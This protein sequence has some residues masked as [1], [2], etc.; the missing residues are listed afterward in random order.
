[1]NKV[2]KSRAS[3]KFLANHPIQHKLF[4]NLLKTTKQTKSKFALQGTEDD[5]INNE[6]SNMVKN[7]TLLKCRKEDMACEQQRKRQKLHK[8]VTWSKNLFEIRTISC[9]QSQG[10]Q[11]PSTA[12]VISPE[13][14]CDQI[15]PDFLQQTFMSQPQGQTCGRQ[16]QGQTYDRQS[17]GQTLS[18]CTWP[19]HESSESAEESQNCISARGKLGHESIKFSFIEY[20]E[21]QK[22]R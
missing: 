21:E 7:Q 17:Q 12:A 19:E 16:S 15:E 8:R 4:V 2:T 13:E 22:Q 9:R 3:Q 20:C 14:N 10:S 6:L 1:M 18:P 11:G 5:Q